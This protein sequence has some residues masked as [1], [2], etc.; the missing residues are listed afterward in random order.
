MRKRFLLLFFC[1]YLTIF[2]QANEISLVSW[3]I[4]DFGKTKSHEELVE[5]A[6]IVKDADIVALQEVVSGYGGAQA[7]AKLW[8]IL[9]RKGNS[10]DYAISD[11][12]QSPKY[13]TERYAFLWK[14]SKVRTVNKGRLVRE[15]GAAI[16]REPFL[17]HFW[18]N[19]QR[20]TIVNFHSRPYN[21]NPEA[22]IKALSSYVID[23]LKTPLILAGDFNVNEQKPVFDLL[24]S[25]GYSPTLTHQK[26]TLKWSCKHGVYV[27]HPIDNIF[28]SNNGLRKKQ[29][30]VIDFVKF[31]GRLQHARRLSDH[32]PVFLKFTLEP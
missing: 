18:A 26:T 6:N 31:C 1:S 16:D 20:F 29:G 15:L 2:S 3:N 11:P 14:K 9:N 19:D 13:M 25:A 17:L 23:S 5:I 32:L 21:K 10:W 7:V 28:F 12:T 24:K 30:G 4:K 27:N 8:D 22:E